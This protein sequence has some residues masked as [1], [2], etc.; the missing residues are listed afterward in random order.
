ME[1]MQQWMEKAKMIHESKEQ[2]YENLQYNQQSEINQLQERH[3]V[4][5]MIIKSRDEELGKKHTEVFRLERELY[6][7][8]DLLNGYRKALND[9]RL[10]FSEY[11][12][13]YAHKEEP[14]YKDAGPGGL[15]LSTREI[16]KERLKQNE[17]L[18]KFGIMAENLQDQFIYQFKMHDDKVLL[19]ADKLVSIG[20]EVNRLK[21]IAKRCK[22]TQKPLDEVELSVKPEENQKSVDE[23]DLS[24]EPEENQKSV[25]ENESSAEPEMNAKSVDEQE[26]C[27]EPEEIQKDEQA[28]I[29]KNDATMENAPLDADESKV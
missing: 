19:M 2:N 21:E 10:K 24:G 29:L 11:R 12:K 18:A 25:V 20:N 16:E 22:E 13:R 28:D 1:Q 7:M 27:A 14:L 6:L 9:T 15:V 26:E 3:N 17:D 23:N 8:S 5:E 4:L